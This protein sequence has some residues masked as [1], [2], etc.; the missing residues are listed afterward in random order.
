M[1]LAVGVVHGAPL[2]EL[3]AQAVALF[4]GAGVEHVVVLWHL[5]GGAARPDQSCESRELVRCP[6]S[7][8]LVSFVLH[9]T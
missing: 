7:N 9:V 2:R 6:V 5:T 4:H 8:S 1:L 3:G